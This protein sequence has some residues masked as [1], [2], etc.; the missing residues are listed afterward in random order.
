MRRS[1]THKICLSVCAALALSGCSYFQGNNEAAEAACVVR[2]DTWE[3]ST[4]SCV[5]YSGGGE[6]A[7]ASALPDSQ[8]GKP[9]ERTQTETR[10][11]ATHLTLAN[12]VVES[13]D[14]CLD[15]FVVYAT[16]TAQGGSREARLA[17]FEKWSEA[18]M[19]FSDT[20]QAYEQFRVASLKLEPSSLRAAVLNIMKADSAHMDAVELQFIQNSVDGPAAVDAAFREQKRAYNAWD[21]EWEP[22]LI[23]SSMAARGGFG[24]GKD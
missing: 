13:R 11:L 22:R 18:V 21:T 12:A 9:R 23:E 1:R 19:A 8:S 17:Y 15:A 24:D 10:I 14:V 2:G 16:A 6:E 4:Q 20:V 3:R 5:D 7:L